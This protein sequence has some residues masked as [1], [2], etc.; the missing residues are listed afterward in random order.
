MEHK[1]KIDK[2]IKNLYG[3]HI[4]TVI[5]VLILLMVF[6]PC[7]LEEVFGVT[8]LTTTGFFIV[9]GVVTGAG[10]ILYLMSI[11]ACR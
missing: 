3:N 6:F 11:R 2:P 9:A 5:V 7:I 1:Q 10:V 4:I 8:H